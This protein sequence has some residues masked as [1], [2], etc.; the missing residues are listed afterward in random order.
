MNIFQVEVKKVSKLGSWPQSR[1]RHISAVNQPIGQGTG[2]CGCYYINKIK[3]GKKRK[4]EN[5]S[6]LILSYK[7]EL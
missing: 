3:R 5:I 7:H 1:S 2:V 4:K 6:Y